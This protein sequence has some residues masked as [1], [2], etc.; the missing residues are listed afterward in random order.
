VAIRIGRDN[1]K[2]MSGKVHL[3]SGDINQK[4]KDDLSSGGL[5][6]SEEGSAKYGTVLADKVIN[7]I[8]MT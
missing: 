5:N 8:V 6:S 2:I 4:K 1:R 3:A 7:I